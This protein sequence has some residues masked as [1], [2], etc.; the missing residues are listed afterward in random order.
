MNIKNAK[1]LF[2]LALPFLAIACSKDEPVINE[3]DLIDIPQGQEQGVVL[4]PVYVPDLNNGTVNNQQVFSDDVSGLSMQ[5]D[6][7]DG[8]NIQNQQKLVEVAG[9][10][11]TFSTDSYSLTDQAKEILVRQAA[12]LRSSPMVSITLEG[13]CDERGTREYNL[14]LGE[15]RANSVK[16]F[17]VNQGISPKRITTISYG[18]EFPE[19]LG[20]NDAAWSKNR[21]VVTVIN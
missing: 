12:W 11:I 3:A 20:S 8:V 7:I 2:L 5:Q 10:R 17:L 15:R 13:H 9:D 14:A 18:K 21:R 6:S 1:N 4:E 19:Y 16:A